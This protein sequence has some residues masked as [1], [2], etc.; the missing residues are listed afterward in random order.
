[1]KIDIKLIIE[2]LNN[3]TNEQ[4]K[5]LTDCFNHGGTCH[6]LDDAG[7]ALT[8]I[9]LS[10]VEAEEEETRF[11]LSQSELE[12]DGHHAACAAAGVVK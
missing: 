11:E 3:S 7:A 2:A 1:M 4:D 5:A 6:N 10:H 12:E 9:V 8:E